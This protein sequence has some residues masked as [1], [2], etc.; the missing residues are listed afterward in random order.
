MSAE[1]YPFVDTDRPGMLRSLIT[2]SRPEYLVVGLLFA[3]TYGALASGGWLRF[4]DNATVILL[5]TLLGGL[6]H[7]L[8]SQ[9]NC[10]ADYDIDRRHKQRLALAVDRLGA[11]TLKTLI[12]LETLFAAGLCLAVAIL[13]AKP[14]IVVLWLAGWATAIGYSVEPVRFKRRGWLNPLSLV[15]VIYLLPMAFG[16]WALNNRISA[17]TLV[18]IGAI[19]VQFF[20]LFLMNEV[21]DVPED[22]F[23][24]VRTPCVLYGV[25]VTAIVALANF[26]VG[27][28]VALTAFVLSISPSPWRW[29]YV[30][31]YVLTMALIALD[32][33][34]L[35]RQSVAGV[36]F[37]LVRQQAKRNSIHFLL[38]GAL[39]GIGAAMTMS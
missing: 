21:E 20:A 32:I 35:Q 15:T 17:T 29:L 5:G 3:F 22:R 27:S 26:A 6:S 31:I 24:A 7:M 11:T 4:A 34:R 13:V 28:A 2:V 37:E 33:N 12:A 39:T 30:A 18:L 14:P 36:D 38:L 19:G 25:R 1:P 9:I 16:Y 8:G 23:C 10:L